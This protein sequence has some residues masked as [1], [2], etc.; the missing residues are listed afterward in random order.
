MYFPDSLSLIHRF[1]DAHFGNSRRSTAASAGTSPNPL[2]RDPIFAGAPPLPLAST[3]APWTSG[4]CAAGACGEGSA[5]ALL[6]RARLA[7]ALVT[8]RR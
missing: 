6:L 8:G 5:L 7:R 3:R 4:G 2:G 1:S